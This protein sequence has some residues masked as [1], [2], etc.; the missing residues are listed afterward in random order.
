MS[1]GAEKR[2]QVFVSS[3]YKDL[4]EERQ[5]VFQALLWLDCFPCGM[6]LFP[7]SNKEVWE[8][9]KSLIKQCDYYIVVVGGKYGS[10]A[11]D[12][13]SYTEKEFTFAVEEGIPVLAFLHNNPA[14]IPSGKSESDADKAK[15]L[16]NFRKVCRTRMCCEWASPADLKAKVMMSPVKLKK[17]HPVVGWVR[18]D[19]MPDPRA[20]NRLH[21]ENKALK[22]EVERLRQEPPKWTEELAQGD[23]HLDVHFSYTDLG[24]NEKT[25]A[26]RSMSWNEIFSSIAPCMIQE[27]SDYS[28]REALRDDLIKKLDLKLREKYQLEVD[29]GDFHNVVV[30]LRALGLI[31]SSYSDLAHKA[32]FASQFFTN[33]TDHRLFGTFAW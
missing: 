30:Q 12:G 23:E 11:E 25:Q 6:E 18:A 21:E 22:E 27:A 3:T 19:S 20:V 28:M 32:H 29:S 9:I 14:D 7:A 31:L 4:I 17:E 13:I 24:T 16:E 1:D 15:K 5:Q 8:A 10:V 33:L 2:Y 26:C